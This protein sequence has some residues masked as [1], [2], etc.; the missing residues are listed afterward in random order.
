MAKIVRGPN[1]PSLRDNK[2][3]HTAITFR[4]AETEWIWISNKA[5]RNICVSAI[6]VT[7]MLTGTMRQGLAVPD[8]LMTW[9]LRGSVK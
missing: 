7:S 8:K 9:V 1:G 2:G 5:I 3:E 4:T 6:L